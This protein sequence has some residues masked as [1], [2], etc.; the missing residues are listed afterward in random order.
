MSHFVIGFDLVGQEDKGEP[1][2][3]YYDEIQQMPRN[4]KLFFHAG[5]T[6]IV[7]TAIFE[8]KKYLIEF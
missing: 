4:A 6:S 2:I 1:I 5:E 3:N 8:T 7:Q